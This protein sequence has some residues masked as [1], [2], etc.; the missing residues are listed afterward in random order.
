MKDGWEMV[1]LGDLLAR[2]EET[3]EI[4]PTEQYK[5]VTIRL[6]GKGVVLRGDV[7][8]QEIIATRRFGV[9]AG[10]FIL[11]RI[12]ARNGAFGIVPDFLDGAVASNDFPAYNIVES[13]M[14]TAYL[15]WMSKTRQFV[16]FCGAASEGTTNRVRLQE[17]RFLA[18][19]IP[20]PPLPEQRRIV[21]KVEEL[22]TKIEEARGLRSMSQVKIAILC[23]VF[24]LK[25][26]EEARHAGKPKP[27]RD[28]IAS[29]DSGWSPQCDE[30]PA[31]DGGWGV[32]KT[33]CVQ[34]EGFD[35]T[36]NKALLPGSD[37]KPD[38][39][40][41]DGDVLITRAGPTNRVGVAC[42]VRKPPPR[43]MLSDKIVRIVP[44]DHVLSEFLSLM[45]RTPTTQEYFRHGKTGLA[46]S[47][48][49]I[50]REKLLALQI[51]VPPLPEQHRIVAYLDDLQAK[52]D[53]LK[54]L[55]GQTQAELDALLPSILDKA[56]KGEL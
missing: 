3:V 25:A 35:A 45:L 49:N 34:W 39:I 4:V 15:G 44:K 2:S 6:W 10:Q 8:G 53:C 9:T 40:V 7:Q 20:L 30:I 21:A 54:A 27:L 23:R 47:Q 19:A 13:R 41:R 43:L 50:S 29:H 31:I 36:A 17:S 33:T 18:T 32:L 12:D 37:P 56:F 28:L 14:L 16:D 38:I 55:Q 48:V 26:E 51:P 52:V 1:P 46:A 42:T 5:E 22:A 24:C 11:S